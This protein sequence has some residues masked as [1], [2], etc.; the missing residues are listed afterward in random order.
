LAADLVL[1]GKSSPAKQKS[2]AKFREM[3]ERLQSQI[4]LLIEEVN[5]I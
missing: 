4:G 5:Q 3:L 2:A 1:G